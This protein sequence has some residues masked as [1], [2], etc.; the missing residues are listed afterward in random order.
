[1]HEAISES[2]AVASDNTG[3]VR[4][5]WP[6]RAN[7]ILNGLSIAAPIVIGS[8]TALMMG[9]SALPGSTTY[10]VFGVFFVLNVIGLGIGLHR[11]FTHAAFRT[12]AVLRA[13]LA[14]TGSWSMQGPIDRW[15]ADHRRHH[16]FTDSPGDPHSPYWINQKPESGKIRGLL[17]AHFLWMFAQDVSDKA[18]YAEDIRKDPISGWCS[19]QYALLCVTS[20]FLPG[21]VGGL[22]GGWDE[23]WRCIL[24][25]GCARVFILHQLTWSVNSIGHMFGTQRSE[26]KNQARDNIALAFLLVGEGLHHYHHQ[27]PRAAVNKPLALDWGGALLL[28]AEKAGLVWDLNL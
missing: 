1:M 2:I 19:R 27:N 13:F 11:Y 22:I 17:H 4:D 15:V 25:A 6:V 24:W 28:G 14:V 10:G 7:Q 21:L 18:R 20:L 3:I 23:A 16:R 8:L 12:S 5:R 26:V 9:A